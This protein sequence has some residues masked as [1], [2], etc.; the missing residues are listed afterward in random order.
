MIKQIS[1]FVENK[2]GRLFEV[3][4][5]LAKN[6]I[7]IHAL[8]IADTTDFGILR[9]IVDDYKKAREVLKENGLT[10]KV[11][12]VVAI[13]M[14]N[15]PGGLAGVLS[16][17]QTEGVSIEYMYAFNSRADEHEAMVI[18]RL[19]DQEA[20]VERI[21][22]CNVKLFEKENIYSLS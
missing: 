19:A 18:L 9:L 17:L 12:D 21:K 20:A 13:A 5:C 7:N 8:S 14:D 16:E 15:T 6:N 10:V 22:N 3:T 1:V 2:C 4:N 11:T